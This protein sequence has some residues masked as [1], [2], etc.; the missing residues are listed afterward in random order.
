MSTSKRVDVTRSIP[1]LS[2]RDVAKLGAGGV[3]GAWTLGQ[4]VQP[5]VLAGALAQDGAGPSIIH[6]Q[7]DPVASLDPANPGGTLTAQEIFRHIYDG[8]VIF[9]ENLQPQPNLAKSWSVSEDELDWTFELQEGVL[10]HDGTPCDSE[11]VKFHFDRILGIEEASSIKSLFTRIVDIQTPS[12]TTIVFRTDEPFG[13]FLNYMAHGG[14]GIVSPA[15]VEEW[16]DDY[17]LHPVGAGPY[18]LEE[19]IPGESATL[20]RF[21]E[22]W[23][24]KPE[25]ERIHFRTI[26]E[27]GARAAALEVG[28]VDCVVPIAIDNVGELEFAEGVVIEPKPVITMMYIGF[29]LSKAPFDDIKVRQALSMAID[30][31]AIVDA[32]LGGYATVADS[33]MALGTFGYSPSPTYDYDPDG[34]RALLEE[35]GWTGGP[36]E[37]RQKDGVSLSFKLWTPQ[38]LYIKDVA[39]AQAAQ[40]FL[41]EV[42]AQVELER[43][44]AANWFTTLKV[45]A[46]E[47]PYDMFMWSLTPSTG[48]G[49]QQLVELSLSD[50]DP[51]VP[52]M[53]WNLTH[54]S[55]PEVDELIRSAGSVTDQERRKEILAEA[56]AKIM[57]DAPLVFLYSLNF[58]LGRKES[59]EGVRLLPNRFV[60]FRQARLTS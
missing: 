28:E 25:I 20:V 13:P 8:L 4:A 37:V 14:A 12:P 60:D 41:E 3:L 35:A 58:I 49:Y 5:G 46:T 23:G 10:F 52:P 2:R 50:P 40:S 16:G 6:G 48:D 55:N 17:P 9:D 38:D 33:P 47:A 43:V 27:D 51:S 21:E 1:K 36:G 54:Y 22:Y 18:R 44:E 45:P 32:L 42:G 26:P 57:E 24:E 29:N 39:V 53:A 31:Q 30:R 7:K 11:A 15:A 19:F 56:Q 59:L 34:A